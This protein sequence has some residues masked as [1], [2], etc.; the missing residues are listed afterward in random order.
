MQRI[1]ATAMEEE[2]EGG[3][4]G[5]KGLKKKKKGAKGAKRAT[6]QQSPSLLS[7]YTRKHHTHALTHDKWPT[8]VCFPL[9]TKQA[10]TEDGRKTKTAG[11]L[12]PV[13]LQCLQHR[14]SR[15]AVEARTHHHHFCSNY[16]ARCWDLP[17]WRS[18][19]TTEHLSQP[20]H[21]HLFPLGRRVGGGRRVVE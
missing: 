1:S 12:L 20:R 6:V 15:G 9:P 14:V 7:K 5:G 21:G 10:A 13:T 17:G 4:G 19:G 2:E 11:G 8:L 3:E 18:G 16:A